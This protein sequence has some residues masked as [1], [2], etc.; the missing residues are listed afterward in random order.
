MVIK[1]GV[2]RTFERG[3]LLFVTEYAAANTRLG[4]INGP[5]AR[6]AK[7]KRHQFTLSFI[8]T[9]FKF[10]SL[11][12]VNGEQIANTSDFIFF[13]DNDTIVHPRVIKND[14]NYFSSG[15]CFQ[16]SL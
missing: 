8:L 1:E 6:T 4:V 16:L 5:K 3:L 11:P 10:K 7:N 2:G 14:F 9:Y 12:I 13:D 15:P